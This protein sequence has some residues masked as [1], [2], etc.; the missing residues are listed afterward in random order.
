M[1][2]VTI[3]SLLAALLLT[4]LTACQSAPVTPPSTLAP[5]HE[6]SVTSTPQPSP[7]LPDPVILSV[8][9][10]ENRLQA[11]NL[12]WLRKGLTDMLIADLAKVSTLRVVQRER[13]EEIIRE[14]KLQA[15]SRF[16]DKTAVRI[17]HLSGANVLLSGSIS[18][19][20]PM[21]R[22]DGNLVS[23]EQGVILGSATVEG[24]IQN[25]LN[26][27]KLFALRVLKLLGVQL[28]D[29]D[30][31]IVT[32]PQTNSI[33]ATAANYRGIDA[34]D[35][36]EI[37]QAL[38]FFQSALRKDGQY[39]N[40]RSNY[41]R[42]LRVVSGHDLWVSA[43]Q[44]INRKSLERRIAREAVKQIIF[45]GFVIEIGETLSDVSIG[46]PT[47]VLVNVQ[48]QV[49]FD[50]APIIDFLTTTANELGGRIEQTETE[51]TILLSEDVETNAYFASLLRRTPRILIRALDRYD[52][53]LWPG[54]RL[55]GWNADYSRW[56]IISPRDEIRIRIK[57][58]LPTTAHFHILN[59]GDLEA[60]G[61]IRGEIHLRSMNSRD[62]V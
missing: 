7:D 43:R 44:T 24:P 22:I 51:L 19:L 35:R 47:T 3:Q 27:E 21:V 60:V 50:V 25:L 53:D 36:G 39:E 34:A 29:E 16:S 13:I 58:R 57:K 54:A 48:V 33:E 37:D 26:M 14:Q 6:V 8:L 42:L 2:G 5:A 12:N 18:I 1:C 9:Y 32:R 10:F 49:R 31:I 55:P 30:M 38:Q 11:P 61:A 41:S 56:V 62:P 17:G 52:E 20:G 40:A 59:P 23:V 4:L 28:T 45:Q 46:P 15:S